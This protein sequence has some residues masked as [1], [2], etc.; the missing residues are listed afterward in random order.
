MTDTHGQRILYPPAA[1]AVGQLQWQVLQWKCGGTRAA[2]AAAAIAK[3][4]AAAAAMAVV[5]ATHGE[6]FSAAVRLLQRL[7]SWHQWLLLQ[8]QLLRSLGGGGGRGGRHC[9]DSSA[10]VVMTLEQ[11]LQQTPTRDRRC[12][13]LA[14]VCL[15]D[16]GHAPPTAGVT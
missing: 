6:G 1:A 12:V 4:L 3:G 13:G 2:S 8:Q 5:A 11:Q 10:D 16:R 9:D 14:A 7:L 15:W